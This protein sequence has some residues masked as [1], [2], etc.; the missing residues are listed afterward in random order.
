[1][2]YKYKDKRPNIH[3]TVFIAPSADIIGD[4]I[5]GEN[6]SVWFNSVVRGDESTITIGKNTN[7]QDCT[8]IHGCGHHPVLIKDGVTVGHDA[9][10]HGCTINSDCIIGMGATLLNGC[11]IGKESIIG[12]GAVIT[13]NTKIPPRSLV[14]GVPAKVVRKITANNLRQI[15]ENAEEYILLKKEY[16]KRF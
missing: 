15:K 6:S 13:E 1:M 12:A 5:I 16:L 10:V 7:I 8:T 2:I 3:K 11:V 9:C 14:V 4:V